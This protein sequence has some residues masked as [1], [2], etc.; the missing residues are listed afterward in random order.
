M[1]IVTSEDLESLKK[2]DD[3]L[4]TVASVKLAASIREF[5]VYHHS[6]SE[7]DISTQ[8]MAY[9]IEFYVGGIIQRFAHSAALCTALFDILWSVDDDTASEF[10]L[11]CLGS[12]DVEVGAC[13]IIMWLLFEYGENYAE[14]EKQEKTDKEE[15]PKETPEVNSERESE[16]ETEE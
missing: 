13:R 6:E 10:L 1:R 16:Q 14:Q 3:L 7:D 2:E 8:K 12:E 11:S 4:F 5:I 9:E 15:S